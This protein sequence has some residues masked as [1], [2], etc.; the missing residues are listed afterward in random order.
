MSETKAKLEGLLEDQSA[1]VGVIGL[2]YVG[3]PLVLAFAEKD[4]RVIGFDIDETKVSKLLNDQNYIRHISSDKITP[5]VKTEQFQPTTDFG[6]IRDCNV[7]IMCVPTPLNKHRE[8]DMS[9]V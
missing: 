7:I 6:K 8:P 4:Y 9:F 1:I 5:L 3:L 2:G